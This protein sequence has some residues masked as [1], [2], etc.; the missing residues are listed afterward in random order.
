[1]TSKSELI[2]IKVSVALYV[3][4]KQS[5][6]YILVIGDPNRHFLIVSIVMSL[7]HQGR[8]TD[9]KRLQL[10]NYIIVLKISLNARKSKS[11]IE[12]P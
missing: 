10:E 8:E 12:N 5:G 6:I 3:R 2:C 7:H 9:F 4:G 1:V 11:T